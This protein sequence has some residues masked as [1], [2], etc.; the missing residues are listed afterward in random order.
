MVCF[1]SRLTLEFE[2]SLASCLCRAGIKDG[3]MFGGIRA[4]KLKFSNSSLF[5]IDSRCISS[6]NNHFLPKNPNFQWKI[7]LKMRMFTSYK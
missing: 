1:P 7:S 4:P 2:E 3:V 5:S 6:L